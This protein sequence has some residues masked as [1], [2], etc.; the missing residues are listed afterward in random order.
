M[1]AREKEKVIL[2]VEDDPAD[3]KLTQ[4]SLGKSRIANELVVASDGVE[5]LDYLFGTGP[6]HG[7]DPRELPAVVLLDLKMPKMD[8]LEVLKRVRANPLTKVLPVVIMTSSKEERDIVSSYES[9]CNAYVRKPVDFGQFAAAIG[10]LGLF[11]LVLNE[12]AP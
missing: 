5:A 1:A 12:T 11:W 2:L 7:R 9:G 10:Q 4:V 3:V 8:G 6:Y